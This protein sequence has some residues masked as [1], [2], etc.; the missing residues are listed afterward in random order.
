LRLAFDPGFEVGVAAGVAFAL[1]EVV[2]AGF[3][4]VAL[5]DVLGWG[6]GVRVTNRV[7][8]LVTSNWTSV[9]VEPS[10]AAYTW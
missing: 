1:G 5:A 3:R 7:A 6:V 8:A 10:A 2:D 4:G 9:G